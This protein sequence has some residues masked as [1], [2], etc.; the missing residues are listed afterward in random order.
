MISDPDRPLQRDSMGMM[1]YICQSIL[2][3]HAVQHMQLDISRQLEILRSQDHLQQ[4]DIRARQPSF[5]MPQIENGPP[6]SPFQLAQDDS[7]RGSLFGASAAARQGFFRPPLPHR[8]T[9]DLARRPE[10]GTIRGATP[11]REFKI[12]ASIEPPTSPTGDTHASSTASPPS[13]LSRRHTSADIRP[14]SWLSVVGT[15][16]HLPLPAQHSP[17]TSGH[18]SSNWPSSPHRTPNSNT[19]EQQLRDSLAR[20]QLSNNDGRPAPP[21][22]PGM[23]SIAPGAALS[24]H[25]TPPQPQASEVTKNGTPGHHHHGSGHLNHSL[26]MPMQQP[27][28]SE[29]PGWAF[30]GARLPFKDVFASGPPTRRGSVAHLLNPADT[31]ERDEEEDLGPDELRKRKRLG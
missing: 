22:G 8:N 19:G 30:P 18:S 5:A 13:Y 11:P 17:L 3:T 6:M 14:Q 27:L 12:P 29:A 10:L 23:L 4:Y 20:Y 7:R 2:L 15:G 9:A 25:N 21:S 1:Q 24:R 28:S 31:A 26:N 16:E